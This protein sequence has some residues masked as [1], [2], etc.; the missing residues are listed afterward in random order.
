MTFRELLKELETM[1]IEALNNE[2]RIEM[3]GSHLCVHLNRRHIDT[4]AG[5]RIDCSELSFDNP[6]RLRQEEDQLPDIPEF[7]TLLK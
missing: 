4:R 1:S 7:P 3:N 2:V 5:Q 6:E